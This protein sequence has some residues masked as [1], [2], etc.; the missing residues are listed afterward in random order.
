MLWLEVDRATCRERRMATKRCK[1]AHF[2]KC[3][4]PRHEEYKRQSLAM[5]NGDA[6]LHVLDGQQPSPVVLAQALGLVQTRQAAKAEEEASAQKQV[7]AKE[8]K[9]VQ[10]KLWE[11]EKL[12]ARRVQGE[13]LEPN[14]LAKLQ[15]ADEWQATK[16][17]LEASLGHSQPGAAAAADTST[18][19]AGASTAPSPSLVSRSGASFE[20][21]VLTVQA[22]DVTSDALTS[23][24]DVT[25]AFTPAAPRMV[26]RQSS[27]SKRPVAKA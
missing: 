17:R 19:A 9:K 10:R 2:D 26:T 14:Q 6:R 1:P 7:G 13:V 27:G 4:W 22:S 21:Q 11:L 3:L 25:P 18:T 24:E 5:Y 8:L 23:I 16:A 20:M 12:E 15:H